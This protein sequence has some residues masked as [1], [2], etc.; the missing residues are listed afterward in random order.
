MEYIIIS[1]FQVFGKSK[2]ETLTKK[3]LLQD[4]INIDALI[5]AGHLEVKS[6]TTKPASEG[7]IK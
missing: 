2:G 1:D 6:T 7:V 3:E 5:S 4:G